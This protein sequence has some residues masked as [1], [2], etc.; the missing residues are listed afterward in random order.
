MTTLYQKIA[1]EEQVE[2]TK[3]RLDQA[4]Q[5]LHEAEISYNEALSKLQNF[6]QSEISPDDSTPQE[7]ELTGSD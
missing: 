1:L 2:L 3:T 4:K 5:T 6:I 7:F